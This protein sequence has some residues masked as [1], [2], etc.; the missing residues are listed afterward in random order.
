MVST[1]DKE[2]IRR[3]LLRDDLFVTVFD[4]V[5]TDTCRFA[6]VVLPATTFLEQHELHRGYGAMAV[7]RIRPA[8]APRGEARPNEAVFADLAARLGFTGPDFDT[9]PRDDRE[10]L[11]SP[12]AARCRQDAAERLERGEV[13]HAGLRRRRNR[14]SSSRPS[15]RRPPTARRTSIRRRGAAQAIARSASL[16][17]PTTPGFPLALFSPATRKTINSVLGE[18]VRDPL[19]C[20]LAPEDAAA[21]GIRGRRARRGPKPDRRGPRDGARSTTRCVPASA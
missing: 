1:P 18:T 11:A 3:G 15:F 10:E 19:T 16:P 5:F 14:R 21:R 7:Q 9:T 8:A 17:D 12:R 20:H 13:V 2:A 6:D 4:Q